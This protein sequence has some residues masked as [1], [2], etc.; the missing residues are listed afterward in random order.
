MAGVVATGVTGLWRGAR[1]GGDPVA[2]RAGHRQIADDGRP[3]GAVGV[4]ADRH[5]ADVGQGIYKALERVL[6]EGETG[7]G[8]TRLTAPAVLGLDVEPPTRRAG[9][10]SAGRVTITS[11]RF[12]AAHRPGRFLGSAS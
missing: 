9:D 8:G 4:D 11:L 10:P 2:C 7:A 6:V 3:L 5:G 1:S 12:A